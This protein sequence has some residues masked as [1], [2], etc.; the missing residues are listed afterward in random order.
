[1]K[2]KEQKAWPC[3]NIAWLDLP[4]F[5]FKSFEE[6]TAAIPS[7]EDD[8]ENRKELAKVAAGVAGWSKHEV[9][10]ESLFWVVFP[11]KPDICLIVHECSHVVDYIFDYTGIPIS[12]EN[13]ESRAYMMGFLVGEMMAHYGVSK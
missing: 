2:R 12:V 9:T 3:V 5:M 1:M 6:L 8:A 4:V 10:N 11:K 7:S 13:T